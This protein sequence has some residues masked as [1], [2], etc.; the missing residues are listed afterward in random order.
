MMVDVEERATADEAPAG[1][2]MTELGVLPEDWRVASLRDVGDLVRGV[3]Y[4]HGDVR[5][6][7]HPAALPIL[8]ATNITPAGLELRRDLVAIRREV[9]KPVQY[10]RVA[11]IVIA[12]SSG[13]KAI[14]GKSA[15]LTRSWSGSFGAFCG[16]FRVDS[17]AVDPA[18][19]ANVLQTDAYR[20]RIETSARGTNINNLSKEHILGFEFPLPPLPEQRAIAHVLSTVQRAREATEAVIAAT[21]ELKRSLM[22]HLFLYG[23]VPV[24]Q[25]AGV[26]LK[27]TEIGL[28]PEGW[29]SVTLGDLMANGHGEI[30]TGPFGSQLHSSDYKPV[31]IPVVNPT[32]LGVNSVRPD[33]IPRISRED[34]DCLARHYLAA[35]DVLLPRRGDF[36]RYAYVDEAHVGWMCGTGCLRLRLHNPLLDNAYLALWLGTGKAQGY[37]SDSAVGT[38]MPNLNQKILNA[39]PVALPPIAQQHVMVNTLAAVDKKLIVER[40]RNRVLDATLTELLRGLMT[41]TKRVSLGASQ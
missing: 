11:D 21:R 18:F 16:V 14:V 13:S 4:S 29:Q 15:P 30:Q 6:L 5:A 37:L 10:L 1:Y 20:R 41:G 28:V 40:N 39:L 33:G 36:S 8:R 24:D 25:V 2:R 12:M 19:V 7:D 38:I 9:V 27:E 34:A 3:T 23:P 31:G 35:G 26:R 22:R 32:H 17:T